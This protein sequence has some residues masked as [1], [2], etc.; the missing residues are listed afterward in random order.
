MINSTEESK[1]NWEFPGWGRA[2]KLDNFKIDPKSMIN[3][4]GK[5]KHML[6]ELKASA[7][8]G[9]DISSSCLYVS[10]LCTAQAGVLAPLVLL[11]VSFVLYLY[12]KIYAEV[13]S[14]LPLNGGT[15]T[16]LLNTTNKKLAAAAACL[17]LLSYIATAV[18]SANEAIHY[19][20]GI[21]HQIPIIPSTLALLGFFAFLSI[22]GISESAVI[23]VVIFIT[24]LVM[25]ISLS[26][27]CGFY[28][29][30][31]PDLLVNN[32]ASW[33]PTHI[34]R[35]LLFGFAAAMLGISG[36]ESS[37][38]FIEE[39]KQGVFP[40]TLRNMWIVVSLFNPLVAFL[41]LGVMPIEEIQKIPPDLL[42]IMG[43]KSWN[44]PFA[45]FISIDAFL[46]LSGAILTSFVGVIGL[47]RRMSLDRCLP[48]FLLQKNKIR[49][50]NHWIILSF[51]LVSV[52]ILL[53]TEG[54]IETLAGVYTISFLSVMSL[55]SIGNML[56]KT[57]R[58]RLP[59]DVR[60]SWTAVSLALLFVIIG[61]LGNMILHPENFIIFL[62]YYTISVFVVAVMFLRVQIL[63]VIFHVVQ[64]FV[65]H[66]LTMGNKVSAYV[67]NHITKIKKTAVVYFTKGDNAETLNNAALYVL[68]N[69]QTNHMIVIHCFDDEK[70]IPK[71]LADHLN[72]IDHLYPKLKIDFIAIKGD[73][74]PEMIDSISEQMYI[75]KN[76][77]FIGTPGDHFPHR[78]EAL[79][80]V[81]LIL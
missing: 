34:G 74:S 48:Q 59:R 71:T 24:H 60:A 66:I 37:A 36:F 75:P 50:T 29:M 39:Q 35:S 51:F 46:V 1:F 14:A 69:E 16:V 79:G 61:I 23:A 64:K 25:L 72:M 45:T 20:H 73:F 80:G 22:I 52:S 18:I 32:F 27:V 55:F 8:C 4:S 26:I 68:E 17:T 28:I 6:G 41:A 49:Q 76:N 9:N 10:A 65:D 2:K 63:L 7:I 57:K 62:V 3:L 81:R 31:Q 11:F 15:Y 5:K 12:R 67:I 58:A 70:T 54:H 38:N 40:K 19:L 47:V 21:F 33:Q 56:L 77:M 44:V 42:A 78:V 43:E 13:G 53:I 30:K